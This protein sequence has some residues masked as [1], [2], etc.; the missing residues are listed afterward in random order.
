MPFSK[1][2]LHSFALRVVGF[3]KQNLHD[4]LDVS[5]FYVIWESAE[6]SGRMRRQP[7]RRKNKPTSVFDLQAV[8]RPG[9]IISR[10]DLLVLLVALV[11]RVVADC[12]GA[13]SI[14]NLYLIIL[15][16]TIP[17]LQSVVRFSG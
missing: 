2:K 14:L 4:W 1:I 12:L 8:S 17:L 10:F 3:L 16:T 7:A 5:N 6:S 11:H 15:Y 9:D 13:E